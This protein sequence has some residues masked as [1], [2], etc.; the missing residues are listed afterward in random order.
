MGRLQGMATS[1]QHKLLLKP[2]YETRGIPPFLN[3]FLL[4]TCL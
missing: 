4:L 2:F 3:K 1:S